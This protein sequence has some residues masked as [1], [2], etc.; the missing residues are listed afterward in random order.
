M[1]EKKIQAESQTQSTYFKSTIVKE[2]KVQF[3]LN[4]EE[5][6]QKKE[7]TTSFRRNRKKN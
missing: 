5:Q 4:K 1:N 2:A 7:K 3:A 6:K